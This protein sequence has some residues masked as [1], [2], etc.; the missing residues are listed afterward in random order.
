MQASYASILREHLM[1][2]APTC[3]DEFTLEPLHYRWDIA[4]QQVAMA[5]LTLLWHASSGGA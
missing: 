1:Q 3:C 4:L 2:V 5:E